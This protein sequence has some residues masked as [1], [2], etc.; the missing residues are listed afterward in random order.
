MSEV[1]IYRVLEEVLVV[2][3]VGDGGH[4]MES[5]P[6]QSCDVMDVRGFQIAILRGLR[7]SARLEEHSGR[8]PW[9]YFNMSYKRFVRKAERCE[10]CLYDGR[11]TL[12]Y[13][14]RAKDFIGFTAHPTAEDEEICERDLAKRA[15]IA[16]G[17]DVN[18][19]GLLWLMGLS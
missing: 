4:A 5:D 1:S 7:D 18:G 17:V 9:E 3:L 16:L 12:E 14:A 6:W 11:Y 10:I 15:L 8:A 19:L 2:P 13:W